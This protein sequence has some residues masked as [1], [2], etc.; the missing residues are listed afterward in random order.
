MLYNPFVNSRGILNFLAVCNKY[1]CALPSQL[2]GLQDE[3]TAYCFNEACAQIMYRLEKGEE[4]TFRT[5]DTTHYTRPSELYK[6]YKKGG[7]K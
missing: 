1:K 7:R 2:M 5:K 4:P 3:Y 6:K